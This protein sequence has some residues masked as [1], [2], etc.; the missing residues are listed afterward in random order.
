MNSRRDITDDVPSLPLKV[1][2]QPWTPTQ[3]VEQTESPRRS[4]QTGVAVITS[5][6]RNPVTLQLSPPTGGNRLAGLA[7]GVGT[8]ALFA[9]TVVYLFSYLRYGVATATTHWLVTDLLLTLQF[10]IPHSILLHPATRR[11]LRPWIAPE[12][13][14]VFYCLCTCASLGLIFRFWKSHP[15]I[16]WDLS[17]MAAIPVLF[18][19][20]GSWVSLLYSISLTGLGYQTGWTQWS[21]WWRGEQMPRREFHPVSLY[22]WM[23]HPVYLSFLGL[24]WFTPVMSL[25]HALLTGVWS[26]YILIGSALKDARLEFFL[27]QSYSRYRERVPGYL[28]M[29]GRILGRRPAISDPDS[30]TPA[31]AESVVLPVMKWTPT[32]TAA[33]EATASPMPENRQAT[34]PAVSD[35]SAI[36]RAA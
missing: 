10:A 36:R 26:V 33:P 6:G 31:T 4:V 22:R 15:L 29:P 12:F 18:G 25:D 7:I 1:A 8:Q 9:V 11:K 2:V 14:G 20:F 17:G 34:S 27:G 21:F 5:T 24:I 30:L 19:F 28:L 32:P 35:S 16:L 13:Y 3:P 23:R